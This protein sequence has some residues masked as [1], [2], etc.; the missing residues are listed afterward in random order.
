MRVFQNKIE[1]E[2][3][4]ICV[5]A[6]VEVDSA[7]T[8]FPE[9][10]WFRFPRRFQ[11]HANM[12]MNSFATALL[13]LCMH[14]NEDLHVDGALSPQ[15]LQ[16]LNEY[17]GI[18]CGW[19]P[20]PFKRVNIQCQHLIVSES[21]AEPR[22]VG[23]SFSGG[24]DSFHSL[25]SHLPKNERIPQYRITHCLMING[26][27]ADSDIEG[28]GHFS[29][30]QSCIAPAI[31]RNGVDLIVCR[32]NYMLFSDPNLLKLT[33][34]AMVTAPALALGRL[35]SC[36]FIPASYRFQEFFRDG[37]HLM[38]DHLISTE[39]MRTIHDGAH[40]DRPQ[41]TAAIADWDAAHHT[42]R[43]CFNTTGIKRESN[44][45]KNCGRCEK[46]VRTMKTLEILG[47][48]EKFHTFPGRIGR[49]AVWACYFGDRGARIHG[50][51]VMR[52]A[53]QRRKWGIWIDYGLAMVVSLITKWPREVMQRAHLY[54]EEK[55]E[56]YARTV[57]RLFPRLRRRAYWIRSTSE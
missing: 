28:N 33:F 43:V 12:D 46:C 34:G 14:L 49:T 45:I 23:C 1:T 18:Q 53:W 37:S 6:H 31:E 3:D 55:H 41:R 38:M 17:Q 5:S 20:S 47:R 40:L 10:M 35:F 24:V 21:D 54:L 26:F 30:I 7:R 57:R 39:S 4:E 50:R 15:L 11:A 44:S 19:R 56:W 32:S 51:E 25:W 16:G 48:L 13:P 8:V 29:S 9:K 52:L 36:F 42:L 2:G 22:A 27:D